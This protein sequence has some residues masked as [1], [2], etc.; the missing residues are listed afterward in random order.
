MKEY[1]IDRAIE[2]FLQ[3]GFKSFTMD[4]LAHDL[5]MSKK[6]LYE[7]YSSKTELVEVCSE[8]IMASFDEKCDFFQREEGVI[9]NIFKMQKYFL[10][11]YKITTNRPL[12]ELKKYYPKIHQKVSVR[13]KERDDNFVEMIVNQGIKEGVFRDS[14]DVNF[15]KSFYSGIHKMNEDPDI[16][17]ESHFSVSQVLQTQM[18]FFIRMLANDKGIEQLEQVLENISK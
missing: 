6:T 8:R 3:Y 7:L 15:V 13:F 9:G 10:E 18:E 2:N 4:D 12:W 11:K 16:F 1:I 17:P 5:G 14:I